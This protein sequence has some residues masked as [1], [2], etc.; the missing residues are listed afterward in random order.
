[1]TESEVNIYVNRRREI[2][3]AGIFG[4]FAAIGV[5]GLVTDTRIDVSILL[6][7][8]FGPLLVVA[9][10]RAA[11]RGPILVLGKDAVTDPGR[12]VMIRWESVEDARVSEIRGAFNTYHQL[13]LRG[14]ASSSEAT[15]HE[16]HDTIDVD[17]LDRLSLPWEEVVEEIERRLPATTVLHHAHRATAKSTASN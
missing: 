9:I 1:M 16:G 15:S 8:A 4:V 3:S 10:R 11:R 2:L 6:L 17:L 12:G 13:H 7:V 14:S 5:E